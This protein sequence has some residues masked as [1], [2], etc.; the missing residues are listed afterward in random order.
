MQLNVLLVKRFFLF[1]ALMYACIFGNMVAIVQRLYS[2]ASLFHANL[3]TIR[4]FMRYHK[5]PED[6]QMSINNYVKRNWATS[7]SADPAIVSTRA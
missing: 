2:K 7:E 5:L 4:E 1:T 3:T 6:L